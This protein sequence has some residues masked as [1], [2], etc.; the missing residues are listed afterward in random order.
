MSD[1]VTIAR[2]WFGTPYHHQASLKGVGY[3]CLGL[4][5]GIYAELYGHPTK[6]PP[7]YTRDL[8]EATKTETL[9]NAADQHLIAVNKDSYSVGDVVI[10]RLRTGAMAKHC[11]IVSGLDPDRMIHAF[12]S[13]PVCEVN[14]SSWW[15]RHIAAAY[16]FPRVR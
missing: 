6:T 11:A 15:K 2:T 16:S 10:F 3:D 13:G 1:V 14:M 5:R 9:L 4:V 12:E 7:A 8:A